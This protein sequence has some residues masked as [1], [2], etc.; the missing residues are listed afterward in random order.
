[1]SLYSSRKYFN[2]FGGKYR[3]PTVSNK[4]AP[5]FYYIQTDFLYAYLA[6]YDVSVQSSKEKLKKVLYLS[7]PVSLTPAFAKGSLLPATRGL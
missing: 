2:K 1:M 4:P 7:S 3:G 5:L 6:V